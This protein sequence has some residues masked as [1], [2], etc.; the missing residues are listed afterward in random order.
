MERKKR[1]RREK[2]GSGCIDR[3]PAAPGAWA[4]G[5]RRRRACCR[6]MQVGWARVGFF[7][8]FF[9][10]EE[11]GKTGLTTSTASTASSLLTLYGTSD[12]HH[13]YRQAGREASKIITF[14]SS[15]LNFHIW[16]LRWNYKTWSQNQFVQR[17]HHTKICK[18]KKWDGNCF[19]PLLLSCRV[20][21]TILPGNQLSFLPSF[22]SFSL[23]VGRKESACLFRLLLSTVPQGFSF[24]SIRLQ[25]VALV[26]R[27]RCNRTLQ[28]FPF[29]SSTKSCRRLC[30]EIN[31][32]VALLLFFYV[33]IQRRRICLCC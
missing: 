9:Y 17:L 24:F 10:V 33:K 23:L 4:D 27:C 26:P 25:C 16:R 20:Y 28:I 29:F 32:K 8:S 18:N 12:N 6:E 31:Q 2:R 3:G 22:S 21:L 7:S 11:R 14:F 15:R 13:H 1:R 19:F 30:Q 5:R